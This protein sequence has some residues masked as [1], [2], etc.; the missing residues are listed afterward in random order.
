MPSIGL[1][2]TTVTSPYKRNVLRVE[3]DV[4]QTNVNVTES[5]P[6]NLEKWERMN[7]KLDDLDGKINVNQTLFCLKIML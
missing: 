6:K 5:F 7:K 1:N 3:R 4:K 2:I